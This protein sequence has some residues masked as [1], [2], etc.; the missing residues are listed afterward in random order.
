MFRT[1][2]SARDAAIF[3]P[4]TAGDRRALADLSVTFQLYL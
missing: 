4:S 3:T 2:L 1:N